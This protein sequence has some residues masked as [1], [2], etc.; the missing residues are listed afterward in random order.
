[1]PSPDSNNIKRRKKLIPVLITH[2]FCYSKWLYISHYSRNSCLGVHQLNSYLMMVN[3]KE[4]VRIE[5][6]AAKIL[7]IKGFIKDYALLLF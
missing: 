5:L 3:H 2:S 1:M 7:V 6:D 4:T